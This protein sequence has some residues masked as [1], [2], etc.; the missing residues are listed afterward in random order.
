M[1]DL[2]NGFEFR[3]DDSTAGDTAKL[4]MF[5]LSNGGVRFIIKEHPSNRDIAYVDLSAEKLAMMLREL[6]TLKIE[7]N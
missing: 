3:T 2:I 6:P 7:Q 4:A 5:P 1:P